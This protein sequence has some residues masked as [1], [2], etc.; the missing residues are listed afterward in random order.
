M[1]SE[2]SVNGPARR[3][4]ARIADV[5][6]LSEEEQAAI[7]G[8]P[9]G[10]AFQIDDVSGDIQIETLERVS[11][12]VGIYRA[13]HAIFPND[14]QAD[15]WIRRANKAP[16]FGGLPALALMCTG[17]V[18]DLASVRQHLDAQGPFDL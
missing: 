12:L 17:R 16:L 8:Q 14:D 7:L 3:V 11:Y 4:F 9:V 10:V 2:F 13:L 15:R 5:W 1:S 18:C 6:S